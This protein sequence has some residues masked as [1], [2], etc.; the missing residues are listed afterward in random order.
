MGCMHVGETESANNI[1][2]PI[3]AGSYI[4]LDLY[5]DLY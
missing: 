4:D 1:H 5:I 3:L 2:F